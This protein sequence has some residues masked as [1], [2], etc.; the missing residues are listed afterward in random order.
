MSSGA[1]K[2]THAAEGAAKEHA[3]KEHAPHHDYTFL[4]AE[5]AKMHTMQEARAARALAADGAGAHAGR[6]PQIVKHFN[7]PEQGAHA[8]TQRNTRPC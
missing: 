4:T 7:T 8:R 5:T 6:P 2:E 1:A 3:A